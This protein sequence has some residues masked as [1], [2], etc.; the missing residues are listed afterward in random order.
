MAKQ[1]RVRSVAERIILLVL[2]LSGI[3]GANVLAFTFGAGDTGDVANEAFGQ[4]NYFFPASFVFATIWP[5]IY[6]FF[7]VLAIH[8]LLPSQAGNP[9]YAAGLPWMAVSVFLNTGWIAI[10]DSQLF[11]W[12]FWAILPIVA[13]AVVGHMRLAIGEDIQAGRAEGIARI[14]PRIYTAWVTVATIAAAASALLTVGWGG[15]GLS[16]ETWGVIMVILGAALGVLFMFAFGDPVFP[17]V[18][19]YAYVGI[20]VR[21]LPSSRPVGVASIGS[22]AVLAFVF[23]LGLVFSGHLRTRRVKRRT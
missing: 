13:L 16:S 14:G 5:T 18:Y 12:S 22:A 4:S 20:A 11:V 19:A 9:R 8:Q 23:V 17:A 7:V 6:L 15:F 10:F 3:V 2:I 21:W 1:H